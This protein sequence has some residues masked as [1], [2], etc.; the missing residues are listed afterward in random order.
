MQNFLPPGY[1]LQV[2]YDGATFIEES[3]NETPPRT[4]LKMCGGPF[5]IEMFRKQTNVCLTVTPPFVS[6]CMLI[7][8]RQPV[9]NVGEQIVQVVDLGARHPTCGV[10]LPPA[11]AA[12]TAHWWPTLHAPVG[13]VSASAKGVRAPG[14]ASHVACTGRTKVGVPWLP[15]P[16]EAAPGALLPVLAPCLLPRL[17]RQPQP[18]A[19]VQTAQRAHAVPGSGTRLRV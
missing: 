7:E 15:G 12:T 6:Y 8:E 18:Q 11:P 19:R 13:A 9:A 16:P 5:D 1:K 4:A 10:V 17:R 14:W 3:I 2:T